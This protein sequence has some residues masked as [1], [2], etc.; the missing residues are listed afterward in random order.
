MLS[1]TTPAKINLTLEVL[2]RRADGYH[3]VRTVL[4]AVGL[5]DRLSFAPGPELSFACDDPTWQA[6]Q[7][8]VSRAAELLKQEAAYPG[9][10]S[11]R[12]EKRIP[13]A[14][15][16]GGDASDA[17]AVLRGLG[18]LWNLHLPA[19]E[20]TALA[21]KL[22]SD[23]PFFLLGGTVLATGR[24]EV[25]RPLPTLPRQW[26]V[27]LLP[28]VPIPPQKTATLYARLRPEHFT[29]GVC[30]EEVVSLLTQGQPVA[31]HLCNVFEQVADG[32]YPGLAKY[33]AEFLQAGAPAV[34]LAGAGPALF[35][36]HAE[37]GEA[38]RVAQ[39]LRALGR[40]AYLVPTLDALPC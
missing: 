17:A 25:L 4:Q 27:L 40:L 5:R 35:S 38:A 29:G 14:A 37:R 23:V 19:D 12:L 11:I 22:G 26:V 34:H 7:S 6:A 30:T 28:D 9:G 39:G 15:G 36:L 24:G 8:L 18:A 20:L 21:A 10:A 16:L 13:L 33:K 2:G 3:E 31:A 32:A 1:L